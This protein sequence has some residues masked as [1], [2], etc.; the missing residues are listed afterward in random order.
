MP[1]AQGLTAELDHEAATT[2]RLLEL[3]PESDADWKP[4]PKSYSMGDLA[5]HIANI[6]DWAQSTLVAPEFDVAP[7]DGPAWTPRGFTT[8]E[9]L[10]AAFDAGVAAARQQLA[11]TSD[12]AMM[13]EWRLL[14][15]GEVVM[16]M[17]RVAVMRS[18]ILNHLIHHRGQLSVYLRL[19]DVPLPSIYGPTADTP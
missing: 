11:A 15:S 14:K 17:P 1:I 12:E 4:H 2:R 3:V 19:R 7:V 6:F 10:L 8:R 16:A 9:A 18:F 13:E 5:A